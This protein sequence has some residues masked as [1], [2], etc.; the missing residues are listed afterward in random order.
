MDFQKDLTEF[1]N[2]LRKVWS[3]TGLKD[4]RQ[5][6]WIN[7]LFTCWKDSGV[8]PQGSDLE[9]ELFNVFINDLHSAE[10]N[11]FA[12]DPLFQLMAIKTNYKELRD[13]ERLADEI[14]CKSTQNK[15]RE[16]K[17]S[18]FIQFLWI[19]YRI[20]KRSGVPVDA[21]THSFRRCPLCVKIRNG[22]K[23]EI[24]IL[25]L[26]NILI[27]YRIKVDSQGIDIVRV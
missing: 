14:Q 9:L 15:L 17:H 8:F 27:S 25:Y 16:E 26:I 7:G 10:L 1:L 23:N 19:S 18:C 22:T 4:R 5:W 12:C 21:T 11:V 20:G 6:V 24:N 2:H 3:P 13:A